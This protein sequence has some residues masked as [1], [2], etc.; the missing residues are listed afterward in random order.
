MVVDDFGDSTG[1]AP[2]TGRGAV[3]GFRETRLGLWAR[4]LDRSL[5]T[6]RADGLEAPLWGFDVE[7]LDGLFAVVP[8]VDG[9]L[10]IDASGFCE[11]V[12]E[13]VDLDLEAGPVLGASCD[14]GAV[15]ERAAGSWVVLFCW[16]FIAMVSGRPSAITWAKVAFW[17]CSTALA[18]VGDAMSCRLDSTSSELIFG[19]NIP[20]LSLR[21]LVFLKGEAGLD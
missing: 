16:G 4:A 13:T 15:S 6:S 9:F 19:P 17:G 21:P 7:V 2:R 3:L 11:G 12:S 10:L 14:W 18:G 20:G 8:T 1:V 5:A